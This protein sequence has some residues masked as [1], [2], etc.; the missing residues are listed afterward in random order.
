MN[1]LAENFLI[2]IAGVRVLRYDK[3][4]NFVI[5]IEY[6]I[7][8]KLK[9]EEKNYTSGKKPCILKFSLIFLSNKW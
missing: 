1:C 3:V 9:G 5:H 4:F 8:D 2:N 6:L 7:D